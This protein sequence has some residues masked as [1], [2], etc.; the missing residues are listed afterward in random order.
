MRLLRARPRRRR[1][2]DANGSE[3][4]GCRVVSRSTT[5]RPWCPAASTRPKRSS[6][7]SCR[8]CATVWRE[9][10]EAVA[11]TLVVRYLGP[12]YPQVGHSPAAP[13]QGPERAGRP[14]AG[15]AAASR[16]QAA[17][18]PMSPG[19]T[20]DV[21]HGQ[22]VPDRV[23]LWTFRVD[24]WGDPIT[25]LAP[26]GHRQARRRAGR[27][28]TATTTCWWVPRLLERAATGVPRG[29][30]A[31]LLHAAA[32]LREPGDPVDPRRAGAVPR[33]DRHCWRSTRCA[34]WSPAA[35]RTA[36]GW[37]GRWPAAAPGTSCSRDPPAAGTPTATRCTARSRPP[38]RRCRGSPRW[39]STSSICRRSTRSARCT[40]RAATTR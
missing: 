36:S 2:T 30:R 1:R 31:P 9:G 23:G 38:P 3:V 11:A 37:T 24:G 35:S 14:I 28:G 8:C 40:A 13:R 4:V 16:G 7:K 15:A 32:A 29:D 20:P 39:A 6:A 26:R 5:S 17:L 10:H 12:A 27:D 19:R 18:Y 34:N 25:T 22:F 21:F 33:G